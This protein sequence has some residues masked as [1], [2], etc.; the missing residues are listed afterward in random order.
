M[1]RSLVGS[2]MC[3][4]DRLNTHPKISVIVLAYGDPKLTN[5]AVS[6]L[7]NQGDIYPNMEIIIVDNGSSAENI[8]VM[9]DY[10]DKFDGIKIIENGENLGFAAGNNVGLEAATGEYVLLLNNDTFVS[11]GSLQAMMLHLKNNPAIGAIGPLTNN[12]GNEAKLPINYASMEEM[13]LT[14]RALKTGYRGKNFETPVV[15]YFA[16]M[17][18]QR[19]LDDFGHLSIDYGRGMFEDD[20]HCKV[21][22]TR[23]FICAVAEDAFVHHHLSATF[24]KID[25]EERK[26]LF[27]DNKA[28][29]ESKWGTWKPHKYRDG[30]LKSDLQFPNE[31]LL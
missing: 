18:R 28:T 2:E 13:I 1:L 9:R 30:R 31:E 17:F 27:D 16:V 23:G 7:K 19:D 14:T 29:F 5:A 20:D 12:I 11:P 22:R 26:K 3:I 15:A 24:S 4:R 21:I 10:A 25:D 6:S 8:N